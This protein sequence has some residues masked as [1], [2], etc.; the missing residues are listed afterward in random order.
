MIS[1]SVICLDRRV[2]NVVGVE[3]GGG[4]TWTLPYPVA[5][6]GSQGR[7]AVVRLDTEVELPVTRPTSTTVRAVGSF[8]AAPV[9]IG[10][11]YAWR[12]VP[13]TIYMRSE[14]GKTDRRAAVRL[15]TVR[16]FLSGTRSLD[17][18]VAVKGRTL[19]TIQHRASVPDEGQTLTVP[20]YAESKSAALELTSDSP[21][22]I[23][24]GSLEWD[25]QYD[26]T[27]TTQV[28]Q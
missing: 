5:V 7:V 20:V 26:P 21:W 8:S 27:S 2:L 3:A 10:V 19:K 13:T 6:D 14:D 1:E 24:L 15:S 9:A 4:T 22:P 12:Y 18:T 17:A 28:P 16:A 23:R 25:G 11:T